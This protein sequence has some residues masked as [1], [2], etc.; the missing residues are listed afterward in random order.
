MPESPLL[1]ILV[2]PRWTCCGTDGAAPLLVELVGFTIEPL[3]R[4]QRLSAFVHPVQAPVHTGQHVVIRRRP[5]I[6]RDRPVQ[7]IDRIVEFPLSLER[8]PLLKPRPV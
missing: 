6:E 5:R 1:T 2:R 8:P 7:R 4:L 3:E